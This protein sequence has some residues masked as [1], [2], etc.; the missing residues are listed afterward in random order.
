MSRLDGEEA[1]FIIVGA[2]SAGCALAAGLVESGRHDVLLIEA[3]PKNRSPWLKVPIG[4]GKTFY[5]GRVNWKYETE[6]VPGLGGRRSY[7]PRGRVLGGSSSINAMVYSRGQPADFDAWEAAGNPGWGWREVVDAYRRIEDHD[8]GAGAGH[9]EGGALHVTTTESAAHPLTRRFVAAAVEL[10]LRETSDLNGE[11]IEG[12]GYYQINTRRGRRESSATAFLRGQRGLRVATGLEALRLVIESGR[13]SGVLCRRR[14]GEVTLRARRAVVLSAGSIGS[15]LLLQLSGIGPGEVLQRLGLPVVRD[16]PAVGRN[17]QD[18]LCHDLVFRSTVPSLNGAL[19]PF[20]GKVHAALRYALSRSGP[21][22]MSLNQGGGFYRSEP[23]LAVPDMQLYCSPLSYERAPSGRRPLMNPDPFEGFSL[24]VSP[25]KPR[26]CGEL[27]P[28]GPDWRSGPR[29]RPGY[30]SHPR[31]MEVMLAGVRFLRRLAATRALA[32]A[33]AEELRPGPV[34]DSDAA[35]EADIRARCYSVFHPVG[36]CRMGPDPKTSVVDPGLRV[37]GVP[38]LFV[39][40][41]SIFPEI[42]SGNTNAPSILVGA[43]AAH[44]VVGAETM[45]SPEGAWDRRRF[46]G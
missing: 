18:H 6:P 41:A 36:T 25:C 29:I 7:W 31:D 13:V 22:S 1:D 24:S 12:A 2:G 10:G 8:L 34:A 9:G 42:T 43:L 5:D 39:A 21:L 46:R 20:T 26:S 38:G 33:I 11:T 35:L 3:G 15:P 4:Y 19:R 17:L 16:L 27:E 44:L 28:A 14:A 40:D 23:G 37:H 30:F 32:P 45:L